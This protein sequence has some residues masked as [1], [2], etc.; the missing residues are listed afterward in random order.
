MDPDSLFSIFVV[1]SM[2]ILGTYFSATETAFSALNRVRIKTLADENPKKAG[3]TALVLRLHDNFDKLLSTLLVL[4][5]VVTLVAA[6]ISTLLFVRY[7][8]DIGAT[9]S[10]VI[11]TVIIVFFGDITP[12]SLAKESPEKVAMACA[13]LLVFFV[14]ITTPVSFL[15]AKWKIVLG[16]IFKTSETEDTMTEEELYSYVEVAHND[17]VIDEG[18]KQLLDNAIEFT[19]LKAIDIL[20]P[21]TEVVAIADTATDEELAKLFYETEYSRL[22]V[23]SDS[24]DNIIAIVNMRDFFKYTVTKEKPLK[25]IYIEPLFVAPSAKISDLFKMLQ[26]KKIHFAVV[27][28]EYGGTAGIV[29]MEDILEELVGDIWDESDEIIIEFERIQTEPAE[30]AESTEKGEQKHK[31]LC[32][33]Y[34]KDMFAYFDLSV[35]LA[36]EATSV[37]GWIMDKLEKVPDEGDT[38]TFENL[39][40]EVSKTEHRRAIECIITVKTQ[41]SENPET[42]DISELAEN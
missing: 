34:L 16:K 21:R 8:G 28:D 7:F 30:P 10:T 40:V 31:V 36:S 15:F 20:T 1:T 14:F 25:N 33:A 18:G 9:M 5:N 27:T 4:N 11:L 38:F 24:I 3:R 39:T 35:D 2:I 26:T 17:G 22:P 23:Y 37:S 13:P 32:S 42:T 41:P 19:E 6:A 29:T 12:K